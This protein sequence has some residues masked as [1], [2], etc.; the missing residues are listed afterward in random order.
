M[1]FI[2]LK[3]NSTLTDLNLGNNLISYKG[4]LHIAK[5]LRL[6]SCKIRSLHLQSNRLTNDGVKFIAEAL[7][8]NKESVLTSLNLYLTNF[9]VEGT[10]ALTEMLRRNIVLTSLNLSFNE[11]SDLGVKMIM[12]ALIENNE[13]SRLTVLS[14]S[15][16]L[17][18]NITSIIDMLRVNKRLTML[19]LSH[20][21]LEDEQ[22]RLLLNTLT[23]FNFTITTIN[24]D[25]NLIRSHELVTKINTMLSDNRNRIQRKNL[26]S[27]L[28]LGHRRGK[29][30]ALQRSFFR[31]YLREDYLLREISHYLFP[32]L[33]PHERQ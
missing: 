25:R 10:R 20:N 4:A 26:L 5:V 19:D 12:D 29:Q 8:E 9:D 32:V 27:L 1:L 24:L 17:L 18:R 28:L 30:S 15:R 31:D 13:R 3:H 11:I 33:K 21:F 6:G 22:I 7:T 14:L 23:R 2:G 16:T